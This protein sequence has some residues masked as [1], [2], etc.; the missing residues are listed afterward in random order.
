LHVNA[1]LLEPAHQLGGLVGRYASANTKCNTHG[2][3]GALLLAPLP[4]LDLGGRQGQL[5]FEDAR[6]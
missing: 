4:F 2:R 1:F 6:A 3:R 5:I